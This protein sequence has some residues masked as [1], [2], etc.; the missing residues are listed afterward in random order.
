MKCMREMRSESI[1]HLVMRGGRL[2]G[3][4]ACRSTLPSCGTVRELHIPNTEQRHAHA[5]Q[6][7]DTDTLAQK[8]N[9]TGFYAHAHVHPHSP[10]LSWFEP[11]SLLCCLEGD[12]KIVSYPAAAPHT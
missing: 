3:A 5:Y 8:K 1:S 12:N 2:G 10:G 7:K 4:Q 11:L 6:D 9:Q